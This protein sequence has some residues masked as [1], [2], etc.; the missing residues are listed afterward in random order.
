MHSNSSSLIRNLLSSKLYSET[1][2]DDLP[3]DA[4]TA[5]TVET[6]YIANGTLRNSLTE[7]L[8]NGSH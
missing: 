4:T 1:S 5:S 2:D 3:S 7:N 6:S 8:N